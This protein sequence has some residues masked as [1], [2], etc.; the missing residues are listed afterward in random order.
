MSLKTLLK[1]N[2]Y[3]TKARVCYL[4]AL[5]F[6]IGVEVEVEEEQQ[7]G[8]C[9]KNQ[10]PMHPLWEITAPHQWLKGMGDANTK[11]NL[12]TTR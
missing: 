11:L 9:I 8:E 2:D 10:R 12:G 1:H 6:Q 5:S 4:A 7:N 3:N